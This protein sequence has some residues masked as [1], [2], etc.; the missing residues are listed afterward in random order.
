M[1]TMEGELDEAGQKVQTFS[2]RINKYWDIMD[3]VIN[4]I[5]T[6]VCYILKLSR[7]QSRKNIFLSFC[8]S[9]K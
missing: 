7:E 6:A 5:N 1:V 9:V 4:V 8:V 2:C 3:N